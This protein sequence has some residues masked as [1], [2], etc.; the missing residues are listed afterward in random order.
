MLGIKLNFSIYWFAF[1]QDNFFVMK[2][3]IKSNFIPKWQNICISV[4]LKRS[5]IFNYDVGEKV[6]RSK[7]EKKKIALNFKLTIKPTHE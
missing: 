5:S 3:Y 6:L 1:L 4:R 2:N 7:K